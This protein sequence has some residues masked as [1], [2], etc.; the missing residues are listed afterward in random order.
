MARGGRK[1]RSIPVPSN[2]D[3]FGR[4]IVLGMDLDRSVWKDRDYFVC[5]CDCGAKNSVRLDS[6]RSGAISSCGCWHDESSRQHNIKH[7]HLAIGGPRAEHKAWVGMIDRCHNPKHQSFRHYGA[8]G[9][10]VCQEWRDSF[11]S[12][13]SHVGRRPSDVLSI[14][15]INVN[16][17]YEPGNVRWADIKT[18]AR[19]TRNNRI[20]HAN[21][22]TLTMAEW[23]E[24]SGITRRIIEGRMARGWTPEMAINTP[25]RQNV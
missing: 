1:S 16:G 13:L 17:N 11:E 8:R 7:G 9:I 23:V 12:F 2:G 24:R 15:R 3:R 14:D 5:A 4:L 6:L 20:V 10:S 18:Q 19:N 25:A 21:G 22:E